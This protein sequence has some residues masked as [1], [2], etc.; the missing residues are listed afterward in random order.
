[1][2][3]CILGVG[4]SGTTAL[5]S[6]LQG[7]L[8]EESGG[9]GNVD[10]V[11]EPFL[12]DR[13]VFNDFYANVTGKFKYI[14]SLS[15]EGLYHHLK[16]PLFIRETRPYMDNEYLRS[17]FA[18][19]GIESPSHGEGTPSHGEGTPSHGEGTPS[20]G[21][22]RPLLAKLIRGCGRFL[23]LNELCP[24]CKFIYIIRN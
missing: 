18:P 10:C 3:V 4:R 20:H 12:W 15:V 23:L 21:E 5:Y 13:Q 8:A 1:M 17:I 24:Q 9:I 16:L 7:V 22:E 11:Y 14:D 6:L 19:H 2:K